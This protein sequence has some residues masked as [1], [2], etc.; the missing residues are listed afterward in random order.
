M[1]L[2]ARLG[3]DDY[4]VLLQIATLERKCFLDNLIEVE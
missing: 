4:P 3:L 2:L 1:Q